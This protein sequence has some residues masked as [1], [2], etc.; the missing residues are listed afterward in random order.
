VYEETSSTLE[1]PPVTPGPDAGAEASTASSSRAE[2]FLDACRHPANHK[3]AARF[4]AVGSSGYIVNNLAFALLQSGLSVQHTAAFWIASLIGTANNF[5]WN[6]NWTFDAKHHHIGKQG[7]RFLLVSLMIA[8]L[9]F[10]IY[11]GLVATTGMDK[12]PANALAYVIAMPFSF[13]AQKLW[14]FKA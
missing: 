10:A 5:W 7:G 14:S 2:L 12:L 8:G 6:R 11:L 9:A 13:V 1:L 4:L 3:Q